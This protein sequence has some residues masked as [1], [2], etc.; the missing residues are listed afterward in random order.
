MCT[1]VT[2]ET[3]GERSS[4]HRSSYLVNFQ[5]ET[6]NSDNLLSSSGGISKRGIE[7][8]RPRRIPI[9]EI[10]TKEK[11]ICS[12]GSTSS[13]SE[14]V[15]EHCPPESLSDSPS[16]DGSLIP[17]NVDQHRSWVAIRMPIMPIRFVYRMDG[18]K[19]C[20]WTA[21]Y[22]RDRGKNVPLCLIRNIAESKKYL[23][24]SISLEIKLFVEEWLRD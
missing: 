3:G 12:I 8:T 16:L 1:N 13:S 23:R 15:T 10:D 9:H 24:T 22:P 18:C 5:P 4:Y 20:R 6:F 17:G 2:N 19:R 11:P 21:S 7:Q 14:E